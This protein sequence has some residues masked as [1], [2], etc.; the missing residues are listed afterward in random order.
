M[1]T[2]LS[3]FTR[4][5]DRGLNKEVFDN[6]RNLL[7]CALLLAAGTDALRSG[8]SL[9]LGLFG[10]WLAGWGLITLAGALM[11][12]NMCD[13]LRRLASL[14]Y[15]LSLQLLLCLLYVAMALRVVEIV[16]NFRAP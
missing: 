7:M 2:L 15:H 1:R 12:L 11:L 9:F 4:L 14:R 10:S 13:G 5:L 6:L 8:D 3:T 16:W